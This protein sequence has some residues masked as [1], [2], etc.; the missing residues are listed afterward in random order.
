VTLL[1]VM[2]LWL[3]GLGLVIVAVSL[4]ILAVVLTLAARK[5]NQPRKLK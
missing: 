2:F 4:G 5:S 3:V 1:L